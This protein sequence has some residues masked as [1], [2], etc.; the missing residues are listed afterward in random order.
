MPEID[1]RLP[2]YQRLRDEIA[3]EIAAHVWKPGE[4]IPSETDL[5]ASHG[6]ALGTVRRAI[7]VLAADG[8]VERVQGRGTFVR[9]PSFDR[10]L[11]RFLR[12]Q[13]GA[14]GTVPQSRI[15]IRREEQ[16]ED[17]VAA[18][19]G[20]ERGAPVIYFLRQRLV[21]GEVR[22]VEEIWL[23]G[24]LFAPLLVLDVA[25]FGD[26]LYPLYE[27]V[28]GLSVASA[29][30]T[31]TVGTIPPALAPSL[32]LDPGQPV[33]VIERLAR[34]YDGRPLE[35]RRSRAPA[36]TFRYSAHIR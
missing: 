20:L 14:P 12:L 33:V 2:R 23:S 25:D 9:R 30:E 7:D 34:G 13:G 19:L 21:D 10:S 22:L 17:E 6:V 29:D 26:L 11:M 1:S 28:C 4:A 8:L 35:W 18:A 5:A 27:D 32:K 31:L 15:L 24:A 36:G 3:A 16:A